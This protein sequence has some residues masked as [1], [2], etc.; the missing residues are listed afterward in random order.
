MTVLVVTLVI[1]SKRSLGT[2]R[3]MTTVLVLGVNVYCVSNIT[4]LAILVFS[5][6]YDPNI[7][8]SAVN[9]DCLK[10]NA[11]TGSLLVRTV[12]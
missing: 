10:V 7:I 3:G 4:L 2:I 9:G 6:D 1:K 8:F 11:A 12:P 5:S